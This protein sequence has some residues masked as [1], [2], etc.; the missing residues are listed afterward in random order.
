MEVTRWRWTRWTVAIAIAGA[1][2]A[3]APIASARRCAMLARA[4]AGDRH[5]MRDH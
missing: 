3:L 1:I 5:G 4:R 2:V